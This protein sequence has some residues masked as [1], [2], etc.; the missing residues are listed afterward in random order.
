MKI[1]LDFVDRFRWVSL[2]F[3]W[4]LLGNNRW[5]FP[6]AVIGGHITLAWLIGIPQYCYSCLLWILTLGQVW[7]LESIPTGW[8][9]GLIHTLVITIVWEAVEHPGKEKEAI[10]GSRE[11]WFFDS[12]GDIIAANWISLLVVAAYIWG[13]MQSIS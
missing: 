6:H 2:L 10:Y 7:A 8:I 12:L 1:V 11:R 5:V 9:S 4:G 3:R 13:R